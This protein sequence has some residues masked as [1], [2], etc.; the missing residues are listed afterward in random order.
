[1]EAGS[2]RWGCER[3]GGWGGGRSG[4]MINTRPS[5]TTCARHPEVQPRVK[6]VLTMFSRDEGL[7]RTSDRNNYK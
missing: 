1:M 3:G 5:G 2:G 4:L 6:S 7:T